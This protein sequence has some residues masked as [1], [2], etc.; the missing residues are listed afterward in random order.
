MPGA[1]FFDLDRTL[2]RGASGPVITEALKAVGLVG[3]RE[4]PGQA[5]IYRFFD[6]VG[7]TLPSIGLAR[8]AARATKGWALDAVQAAGKAAAEQLEDAVAP[9]A[10]P[11]IEEHRAAGRKL[12]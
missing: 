4:L 12:V 9:Y 7:E 10:R 5:A 11:L 2:L 8:A 1:A 3:D 6:V